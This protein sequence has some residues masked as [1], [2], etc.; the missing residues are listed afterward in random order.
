MPD[1]RFTLTGTN[2]RP[3]H[4]DFLPESRIRL[5]TPAG[6]TVLCPNGAVLLTVLLERP[7]KF[8][9][10][11]RLELQVAVPKKR[12]RWWWPFLWYLPL[13]IQIAVR[14]LFWRQD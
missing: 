5:S 2:D 11:R 9:G 4:V 12:R 1:S 7:D 3:L 10:P 13:P 6:A 8:A 14:R